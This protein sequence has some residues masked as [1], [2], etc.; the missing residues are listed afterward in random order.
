VKRLLPAV[1]ALVFIATG[2][3]FGDGP[4]GAADELAELAS[5]ASEATYA[6]VYRFN[7]TRQPAPGVSTRL[8]IVQQPP[9][10]LRKVRSTTKRSDGKAVDVVYWLVERADGE[11]ACNEFEGVGTRCQKNPVARSTFGSAKID[12]FFDAPKRSNAFSSV[13]KEGRQRRIGG[14]LGTCFEA[15]PVAPSAAPEAAEQGASETDAASDRFRYELCYADD[16]I[17]LR[18][19]RTTL[20]EGVSADNAESFVEVASVSRVVEPGELRLPGPVVSPDDL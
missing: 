8:E 6:A 2:C 16:G 15:V 7:F 9:V 20:E 19:R 18:G 13:R 4:R 3:I 12:P 14:Q 17:L 11:Y 5:S 10:S 1:L